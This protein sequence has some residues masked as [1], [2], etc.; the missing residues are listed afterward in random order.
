MLLDS[1]KN[2]NKILFC[3]KNCIYS[4]TTLNVINNNCNW[5]YILTSELISPL[6]LVVLILG[7]ALEEYINMKVRNIFLHKILLL[8]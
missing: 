3:N 1:K 6:A 4:I 8:N 5:T 2:D 7:M